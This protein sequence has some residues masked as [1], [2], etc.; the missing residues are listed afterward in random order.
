MQDN[1]SFTIGKVSKV[2]SL[3]HGQAARGPYNK[4]K[5]GW[6]PLQDPDWIKWKANVA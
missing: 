3:A 1:P 6:I 2:L 4:I 5:T